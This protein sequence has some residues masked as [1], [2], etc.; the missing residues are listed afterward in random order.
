MTAYL[1]SNSSYYRGDN[2]NYSLSKEIA[3]SSGNPAHLALFQKL[4]SNAAVLEREGYNTIY[5]SDQIAASCCLFIF[6]P[7]I[8]AILSILFYNWQEWNFP[9]LAAKYPGY[10]LNK[11]NPLPN[12][13]LK[14]NLDITRIPISPTISMVLSNP[15]EFN[16][17]NTLDLLFSYPDAANLQDKS[18]LSF[19]TIRSDF[20]IEASIREVLL[21][22]NYSNSFSEDF[23]S[24]VK[25]S[26]RLKS[27]YYISSSLKYSTKTIKGL[28]GLLELWNLD[29][30]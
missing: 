29:N 7:R 6:P 21:T 22:Y 11:I 14:L 23:I 28:V 12:E 30:Q 9:R 5:L 1:K 13:I 26:D 27:L 18:I 15:T 16:N 19:N 10:T 24:I 25:N 2:I 20:N 4:F 17:S 3:S 8:Q